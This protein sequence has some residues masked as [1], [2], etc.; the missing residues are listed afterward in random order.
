MTQSVLEQMGVQIDETAHKASRA[1]S[2][3]ADAL[4]DGG[5]AA[6][7]ITKQGSHAATEL[8][9]DTRRRVQRHPLKTVAATLAAGIGAGAVI[10]WMV[11]HRKRCSCADVQECGDVR[12]KVR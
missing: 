2:A 11:R 6:R 4:E 12:E 1:A 9:D 5:G 10:G 7:R 3:V 8:M